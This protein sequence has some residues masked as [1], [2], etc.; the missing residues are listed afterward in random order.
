MADHRWTSA[1]TAPAVFHRRTTVSIWGGPL[2]D[3]SDFAGV[4]WSSSDKLDVL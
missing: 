4:K 2:V 1:A 3:D